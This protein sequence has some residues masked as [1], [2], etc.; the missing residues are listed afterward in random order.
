MVDRRRYPANT[1]RGSVPLKDRPRG[2]PQVYRGGVRHALRDLYDADHAD[3]GTG[4]KFRWLLS[5]CLAGAVGA[6]AIFVIIAGSTEQDD[7]AD[8]LVPALKRLQEGASTPLLIPQMKKTAGLNW[9]VPKADK[10]QIS[11][12]TTSTRYVIHESV[13]QRREGRVYI[14]AKPFLRVVA[15][16]APVPEQYLD[17][18]PPFNPFKLYADSNPIGSSREGA[19]GETVRKDVKIKVVEL[20]GGVLPDEDKQEL[21]AREVVDLVR[22]VQSEEALEK[23][24]AEINADIAQ[25][26]NDLNSAGSTPAAYTT[27]LA[28][29][30]IEKDYA[31]DDLEGAKHIVVKVGKQ[32]TLAGLLARNGADNWLVDAMMEAARP[33]FSGNALSEGQEIH[34]T[35]LPSLT[36]PGEVEPTSFSLFT[37]GHEHLVSVQRNATGEFVASKEPTAGGVNLRIVTSDDDKSGSKSSRASSL[38]GS[39]YHAGLLQHVLPETLSEIMRIHA[40]EVDFGQR[41]RAGDSVEFFFDFPDENV[42]DGPPGELLFTQITSGGEVSRFYRFRTSDGEIDYY[43]DQGNNSKKFLMRRPVR[44]SD[45]R[46]TS[47]FGMR[48]HPLLNRQRMHSGVDWASPPG[49]PIL[50][51]GRGTIEFAAR[52]GQYGNYVRIRHANGYHTSYAHM[53]K[54][55]RGVKEGVQ[56]RQGQVI[57][58][59]G[60]TGLSSGPHL[61]FEVLVNKRR[62]DPMSIQVPQERQLTGRELAEF[63]RERARIDELIRRAPVMTSSR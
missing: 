32:E 20:I 17:V 41:V 30:V 26:D 3:G 50:A 1:I 49:T 28:K 62:V 56:V 27:V 22:R 51:A 40:Y 43:D 35:L 21:E 18:V 19:H 59:I 36:T 15:R 54:F 24:D 4:G 29:S 63:Q 60:T 58:Y 23:A 33:V 46:L 37:E 52:N 48:H 12:G 38:Y 11:S 61:H 8:G 7:S 25:A 44:G 14:Q 34:I 6:F 16:L 45:V 55:A 39:V 57:G 2:L 9:A 10:L 53:Q 13:K 42:T 31:Q 47:G 5:T